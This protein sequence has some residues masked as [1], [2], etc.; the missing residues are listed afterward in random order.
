MSVP[1]R[2]P[3][4]NPDAGAVPYD[5]AV[6]K[7]WGDNESGRVSDR[8]YVS[9][10]RIQQLV[11]SMPPGGR[12]GHSEN[13]RTVMGADEL[14][15]V[16]AG[17]LVLANPQTGEVHRVEQGEGIYF[18]LGTWHHGFNYGPA[19][20]QVLEFFAP[21][22]PTG[23]SQPFARTRPYLTESSYVQ[24]EWIGTWPMAAAEATARHTQQ[25]IHGRDVMWRL[26][27]S[28]NAVLVGIYLSTD[29]LTAGVV[30]MLP[31][32][33]SEPHVHAGDEAGYVRDGR[34][35]LLF[36]EYPARG[37][38][39]GWFEMQAG[40]GYYVPAGTLHQHFNMSG[41]PVRFMFGVAPRYL[42]DPQ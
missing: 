7:L 33:V 15:Y 35:H 4:I 31:G 8:I 19:E 10:E 30:D 13:Y 14:F 29:E 24:D 42:P 34:L 20:L 16:L 11:F 38:G 12:F 5:K 9:N 18:R 41:W 26:E 17:T 21:P 25:V 3:V 22:P 1:R 28:K 37:Q 36:P 6:L 39:N 23:S 32:Q 2:S 27:G 40:D